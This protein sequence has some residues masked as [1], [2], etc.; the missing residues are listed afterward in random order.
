MKIFERYAFS[1]H[2]IASS[3]AANNVANRKIVLY[4]SSN[5]ATYMSYAIWGEAKK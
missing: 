3:E 4:G 2:F 5:L 1:Q